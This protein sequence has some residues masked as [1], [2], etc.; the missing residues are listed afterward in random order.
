MDISADRESI[1]VARSGSDEARV[2]RVL[3]RLGIDYAVSVEGSEQT[4][5]GAVCFLAMVY[6]VSRSE[7]ERARRALA[8]EGLAERL[9]WPERP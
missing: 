9:L 6:A 2:E 3:N 8:D 5:R 1:C 7:A 4:R